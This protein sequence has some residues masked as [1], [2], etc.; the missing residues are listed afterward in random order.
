MSSAVGLKILAIISGIKVYKSI[1]LKR[2]KKHDE[3]VFL[4]KTKFN[5]IEVLI[6]RALTNS[7]IS[8]NEF[9]LANTVLREYGDMKEA[10][11]NLK[12]STAPQGF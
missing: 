5:T 11:K 4:T 10:I 3:I 7:Y 8:H 9:A 6:S 12:I 2:K 1:N